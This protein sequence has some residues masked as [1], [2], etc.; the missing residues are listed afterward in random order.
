VL[1]NKSVPRDCDLAAD[2]LYG[3]AST[4]GD[5]TE[6]S[7]VDDGPPAKA[8]MVRVVAMPRMADPPWL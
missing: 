4:D 5:R 2:R 6:D 1:F 8:M 7:I 3:D